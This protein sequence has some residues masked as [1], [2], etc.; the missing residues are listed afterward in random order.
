MKLTPF[1]GKRARVAFEDLKH[2]WRD[3]AWDVERGHTAFAHLRQSK[4]DKEQGAAVE[5]LLVWALPQV[6]GQT[7]IPMTVAPPAAGLVG[8]GLEIVLDVPFAP[9]QGRGTAVDLAAKGACAAL[10]DDSVNFYRWLLW[11][12]LRLHDR[13]QDYFPQL[14]LMLQRAA[15]DQREGFARSAGALFVSRLKRWEAWESVRNV[16]PWRVSSRVVERV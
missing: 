8:V 5:L 13:G 16:P 15:A 6:E 14:L 12:L 1:R 3:L 7:P 9:R 11:Q 2:K 4:T 10:G